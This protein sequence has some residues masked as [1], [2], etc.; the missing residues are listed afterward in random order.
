MRKIRRV[1]AI[2]LSVAI[3]LT[4]LMP[5][6]VYAEK[7]EYNDEGNLVY[8]G[9]GWS[10]QIGN[11][12]Y[13]HDAAA[14][15]INQGLTQA[16]ADLD[17]AV[18]D[19]IP[20][21][22]LTAYGK[23]LIYMNWLANNAYAVNTT[24]D[25]VTNLWYS[26]LENYGVDNVTD[27]QTAVDNAYQ[28]YS[29]VSQMAD[30]QSNVFGTPLESHESIAANIGDLLGYDGYRLAFNDLVTN[31]F[32]YNIVKIIAED[33][34]IEVADGEESSSI[35]SSL[36]G[37]V[38]SATYYND[39]NAGQLEEIRTVLSKG[40]VANPTKSRIK[41]SINALNELDVLSRTANS[42][43]A[44]HTVK[45]QEMHG[46][47]SGTWGY[48]G[49]RSF[50]QTL[51]ASASVSKVT[52]A[53][54]KAVTS[55]DSP[56]NISD[57]QT[58]D[59]GD[60]DL[61]NGILNAIANVDLT[62]DG[63]RINDGTNE[64][65]MKNPGWYVLASGLVYE[66]FVSHAGDQNYI[67]TLNR[68]IPEDSQE[69][70]NKLL[71]S[72][73]NT[74][75]PLYVS[76]DTI[77][78][79]GEV[80]E[81][82]ST[83]ISNCTPA[84]LKVA[85]DSNTSATN[86]Y[87]MLKGSLQGNP[88]SSTFAYVQSG[89]EAN[90]TNSVATTTSAATGATAE[91]G[92]S[93]DD[94]VTIS[95]GGSASYSSD[96]ITRP[97][98]FTTGKSPQ[99]WTGQGSGYYAGLG[100]LTQLILNN[101]KL[102]CKD[103][104]L[105][106]R[107][108]TEFLFMNGLGDVVL[109][110]GTIVLPAIAN[111]VIWN[112]SDT[113]K[114]NTFG[115]QSD[116][117][118]TG[119]IGAAQ[120]GLFTFISFADDVL[121]GGAG[122]DLLNYAGLGGAYGSNVSQNSV[123]EESYKNGQDGYY[124]YNAAFCNHYPALRFNA[125]TMSTTAV[126]STDVNKM[127]I[128]QDVDFATVSTIAAIREDGE[129]VVHRNADLPGLNIQPF[130]FAPT[131]DDSE[132]ISMFRMGI[133]S[134]T[135]EQWYETRTFVNQTYGLFVLP[136]FRMSSAGLPFFPMQMDNQDVLDSYLLISAPAVT[137]CVRHITTTQENNIRSDSQRVNVDLWLNDMVGQA[138]LGNQYA[139]QMAKNLKLDYDELVADQYGRFTI[140]FKDIVTSFCD[141]VGH[142]D[143]VLAMKDGYGNGFFNTI[144]SFVQEF[145]LI[146]CVGLVIIVAVKFLKGKFSLVYVAM[147]GCLTIAAFQVYAVWMPTAV[148]ALYNMAVNDIVEDITWS[149]VTVQAE[150]YD[151]V[152]LDPNRV[153]SVTGKPRPYTATI[154]LYKMTQ[155]EM[156][157]VAR[158]AGVELEDLRK[159][160]IVYIDQ[161]A[162]IFAQGDQIK[163]SLDS[164]LANNTMRGLYESQ[165]SEIKATVEEPAPIDVQEAG[166][167]YIVKLTQPYISLES[168]YTPFCQI[169][170]A[171][172]V[173]LNNFVN[174]FRVQRN[175]Y[176]YKDNIYKDGFL[177][178]AFTN[179]GVFL[180][181]NSDT[182]DNTLT[183]NVNLDDIS[184]DF[185]TDINDV[186][187]K[188]HQY[189]DPF[190]D[191]L[192]L[193]SVFYNPSET[194]RNSLWGKMMQQQ[195]YYDS[196]WNMNAEQE[197]KVLELIRYINNLTKQFI[198]RNQD[199]LNFCSDE[200][201]IKLVSLYATTCFT[202]RVSQ[203]GYWL[204]P[205]YINSS[206]IELRDVLYGA[207]TTIKDRNVAMNG[208]VI[209][210]I[211]L[212][213][214]LPGLIM[215]FL[216]ILFSA[217]FIFIMTYLVPILYL[218]FGAILVFKLLNDESS[219]GMIKGYVKVTVISAALYAF[220]SLA[221]RFA[222]MGGYQWYGYL[223]CLILVAVCTYFLVYVVVSVVTNPMELGNDVLA[224][225]L[226]SAMDRL[227]GRRLSRITSNSIQ[228]NSRQSYGQI[229]MGAGM[230]NY[231]RRASV[232]FQNNFRRPRRRQGYSRYSNYD[233]YDYGRDS[234]SRG[235]MNHIANFANRGRG[236][237]EFGGTR[238]G[239]RRNPFGRFTNRRVRNSEP[240]V[241]RITNENRST[242]DE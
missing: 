34:N 62:R 188:C 74:K 127:L 21:A 204:Y 122:K 181:P 81:V 68:F 162:G 238:V 190:E 19:N 37:S 185:M 206:D 71:R 176:S 221:L 189:M 100:G 146:L 145:Y 46:D 113:Y 28:A 152:Y 224:K 232:D 115:G 178:N 120:A 111:P 219:T 4:L 104:D 27:I 67:A 94:F 169:E 42:T 153:D 18:A 150:Q 171:F 84:T 7:L 128:N 116:G 3:S 230:A 137:A 183:Q 40:D 160:N 129:M 203:F 85:L 164:L 196:N 36:E 80:T 109:A 82:Q 78:K 15:W 77:G 20:L 25:D 200:N 112:Y 231:M 10:T 105:F 135:G 222:K 233:D 64:L 139:E 16:L 236:Y 218:M 23:I 22:A 201:A 69:D 213:L 197:R 70:L 208:D 159:G 133:S 92:A 91:L 13:E 119:Y 63:L 106:A 54:L 157:Q 174:V 166:N 143:G 32:D 61:A 29:K 59:T 237:D 43:T 192:N 138:M 228:I 99:F 124:P 172:L 41:A 154:T 141:T 12:R 144:M 101:A 2:A 161:R 121:L 60:I 239:I 96:Q 86:V 76:S 72:A 89:L 110:D 180:D 31:Y 242:L 165:W 136:N 177:F 1:L 24:E 51:V 215:L 168:Y 193:R 212:S 234:G 223:G 175:V 33:N 179:S 26:A 229:G 142:I 56:D 8:N 156:E 9:K 53:C 57:D 38:F 126:K 79:W 227:T 158:G 5:L 117:L 44:T 149:T 184:G 173:N 191:W 148:P 107:A 163:M 87:F 66:P 123:S 98:M 73:L 217:L 211:A 241:I 207:L 195:G 49:M 205:N 202:Q 93:P 102:D 103:Q 6:S 97:V 14:S 210:T 225:N 151:N 83:T 167:P 182:T 155:A 55:T 58:S 35:A 118:D 240:E 90:N 30:V 132:I 108:E 214:G 226:F 187:Q 140:F 114:V 11:T 199:Q 47:G 45:Q 17:T 198:I 48:L 52:G 170:R 125:Q 50:N 65:K 39:A 235:F 220:F 131:S 194:M 130:S 134:G 216:I 88:D 95:S 209:N 186:I 147:I 75:K